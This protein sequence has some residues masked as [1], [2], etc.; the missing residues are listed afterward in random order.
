[1]NY[2]TVKRNRKTYFKQK[3]RQQRTSR[4]Q[5]QEYYN[6]IASDF[7]N[8]YGLK[9]KKIE[10]VDE[11]RRVDE[12]EIAIL[13]NHEELTTQKLNMY[14]A[15]EITNL[16]DRSFVKFIDYGAYFPSLFTT[17][18]YQL[19]LNGLFQVKCN[20]KGYYFDPREKFLF[21]LK[22]FIN[23]MN[24][25]GNKLKIR[26]AADGTSIGKNLTVLNLSF[27]FLN[28]IEFPTSSKLFFINF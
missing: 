24:I 26:L 5:L 15:K 13:Q 22:N 8:K 25:D 9:I 4:F 10:L 7:E 21:Y 2:L 3:D 16:S 27:S 17:K 14:K 12:V 18:K 23:F 1:M 11:T 28:S 20:T 6:F 19:R